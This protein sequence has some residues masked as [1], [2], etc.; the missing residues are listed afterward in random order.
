MYYYNSYLTANIRDGVWNIHAS[1]SAQTGNPSVSFSIN[2]N[3]SS[4]YSIGSGH[5]MLLA[6]SQHNFYSQCNNQYYDYA[7]YDYYNYQNFTESPTPDATYEVYLFFGP[8][9]VCATQSPDIIL[10][11]STDSD[12]PPLGQDVTFRTAQIYG[13]PAVNFS[14]EGGL[15]QAHLTATASQCQSSNNFT[16]TVNYWLHEETRDI[17]QVTA[18]DTG[19]W[20]VDPSTCCDNQNY[21]NTKHPPTGHVSMTVSKNGGTHTGG[22][23]TDGI[24]VTVK[25]H[26]NSGSSFST[27]ATA[28]IQCPQ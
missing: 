14:N 3:G 17:Y 21:D 19:D 6:Y 22:A 25:G 5:Y 23:T 10:G 9:P 11:G 20:Y 15:Q 7:Y 18:T 12:P 26:Y 16:F 1:Q 24:K 8:G 13:Y 27:P 2:G 28:H 4:S